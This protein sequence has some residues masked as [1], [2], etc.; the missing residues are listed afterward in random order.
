METNAKH[1][2]IL[3]YKTNGNLIVRRHKLLQ[4]FDPPPKDLNLSHTSKYRP[5]LVNVWCAQ[6]DLPTSKISF[7]GNVYQC[8]T[9]GIQI[10][11]YF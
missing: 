7:C 5:T 6:V 11:I 1:I 3:G 9:N 4:T 2:K 8:C 10:N